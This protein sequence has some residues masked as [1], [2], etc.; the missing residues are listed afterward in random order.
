MITRGNPDKVDIL[1]VLVEP[2]PDLLESACLGS[3]WR[4][5]VEMPAR[6]VSANLIPDDPEQLL[7]IAYLQPTPSS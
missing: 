2:P 7:R 5:W 3:D 6:V 1:L 4:S